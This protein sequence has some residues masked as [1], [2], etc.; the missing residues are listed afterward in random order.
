MYNPNALY[1]AIL[2]HLQSLHP[3]GSEI[4]LKFTDPESMEAFKLAAVNALVTEKRHTA[5]R[6]KT[7]NS[8]HRESL[9]EELYGQ[10]SSR[11]AR[12]LCRNAL[13]WHYLESIQ[14]VVFDEIDE[15]KA[16]QYIYATCGIR[17][18]REL[19]FNINAEK[20]FHQF[21]ENPFLAWVN[22]G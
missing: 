9:E 4:T 3:H 12:I 8:A 21:V 20:R 10:N 7:R 22:V 11:R 18:H 17:S 15:F 5:V 16:R 6:R 2:S 19:D 1:M 14:S 13:F